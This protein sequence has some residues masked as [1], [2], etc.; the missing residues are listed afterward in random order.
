MATFTL[1]NRNNEI[2][3]EPMARFEAGTMR[4][5][6]RSDGKVLRQFRYE[7]KLEAPAISTTW[8]AV[9]WQKFSKAEQ[10]AAFR[11][12]AIKRGVSASEVTIL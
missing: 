10:L 12:Y 8:R 3:A 2:T 1:R 11:R 4:Y 5:T 6:L 7:G 9:T